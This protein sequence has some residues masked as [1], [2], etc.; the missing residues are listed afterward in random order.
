MKRREGEIGPFA[1]QGVTK[2]VPNVGIVSLQADEGLA[3]GTAPKDVLACQVA[4]SK[5]QARVISTVHV[6]GLKTD[7]FTAVGVPRMVKHVLA[8]TGRETKIG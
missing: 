6:Q 4:K 5:M 3:T 1:L 2:N 8:S 7:D